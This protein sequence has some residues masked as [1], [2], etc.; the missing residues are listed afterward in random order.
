MMF[1]F[2]SFSFGAVSQISLLQG[3]L[4]DEDSEEIPG[5]VEL[6]LQVFARKTMD[7]IE[8]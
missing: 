3:R 8:G 7:T 2:F 6:S 5:G 1:F 4:E